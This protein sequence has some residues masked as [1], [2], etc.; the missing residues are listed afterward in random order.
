VARFTDSADPAH[1]KAK[2][3]DADYVVFWDIA[4]PPSC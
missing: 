4:C 2:L 3:A 1:L